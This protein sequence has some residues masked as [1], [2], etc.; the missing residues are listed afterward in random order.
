MNCPNCGKKQEVS[1]QFCSC[2]VGLPKPHFI[3]GNW[4]TK[5]RAEKMGDIWFRIWHTH[6]LP[7][8]R[9]CRD[10]KYRYAV[11]GNR[12]VCEAMGDYYDIT[13]S[14]EPA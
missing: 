3:S 14:I 11:V 5:S 7:E 10:L 2:P 4:L 8:M 1:T 9:A 12:V 13:E 6:N